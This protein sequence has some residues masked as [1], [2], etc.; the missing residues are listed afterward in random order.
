MLLLACGHAFRILLNGWLS[1]CSAPVNLA[2]VYVC[3]V[4]LRVAFSPSL[5]RGRLVSSPPLVRVFVCVRALLSVCLS[6]N[7]RV[8][9]S[10]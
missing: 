5:I 4:S 2:L 8:T 6:Q 10:S 7:S 1:S 9:I 3:L